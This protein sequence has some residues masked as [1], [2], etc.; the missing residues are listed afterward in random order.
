MDEYQK[1]ACKQFSIE[2]AITICLSSPTS[3][4]SGNVIEIAEEINDFL[5]EEK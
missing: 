5:T 2:K 3:I 1:I 4:T